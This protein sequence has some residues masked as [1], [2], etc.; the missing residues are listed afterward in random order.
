VGI[1]LDSSV[2]VAQEVADGSL[3]APF[4]HLSRPGVGYWMYTPSA[5]SLRPSV[6]AVREWLHDAATDEAN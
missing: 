6:M 5:H 2:L 1:I 4:P 3:I